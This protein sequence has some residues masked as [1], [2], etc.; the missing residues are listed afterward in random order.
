MSS[1]LA[2]AE[3]DSP[4][5]VSPG[6]VAGIRSEKNGG[7]GGQAKCRTGSMGSGC[8]GEAFPRTPC[9]EAEKPGAALGSCR[10]LQIVWPFL[11]PLIWGVIIAI[12]AYPAYHRLQVALGGRHK[13]AATIFTLLA[14]ALLIGPTILLAETLIASAQ[15]LATDLRDGTVA[16]PVPPKGIGQWPVIGQLLEWFWQLA[17]VNL[18]QALSEIGPQLRAFARWLLSVAAGVGLGILQF[19]FVDFHMVLIHPAPGVL[20]GVMA[21]VAIVSVLLARSCA[22]CGRHRQRPHL[23][24]LTERRPVCGRS[25]VQRG[26]TARRRCMDLRTPLLGHR[27]APE[28]NNKPGDNNKRLADKRNRRWRAPCRLAQRGRTPRTA[29][30][31]QRCRR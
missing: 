30:A 18:E 21:V 31:P 19:V 8:R 5:G 20:I 2:R 29:A 12:A 27:L 24:R 7:R 11:A 28:H 3:D 9:G 17:S 13:L 4:S 14:L 6:P 16:V 15:E 23:R 25:C 1:A 26:G 10:S 22:E